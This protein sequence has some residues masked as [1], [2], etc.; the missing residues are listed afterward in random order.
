MEWI[1]VFLLLGAGL[2]AGFVAGLIG[3]GG[4]IIFAPVLFF[5]F[6]AT[7]VGADVIAPLTVGSSLLCTLV[8]AL[9]SAWSQVRRESV[10]FRVA[11][12]VGTSSAAAV[13]LMT[14]FVTTR[15]WYDA[16]VFQVL[17]SLVLLTVVA[18]MVWHRTGEAH[19]NTSGP[20]RAVA[21][22]SS[23]WVLGT[24]GTAAGVVASAV[25]VGGGVV[26]VPAYHN[27]LRLSIHRSVGTSSATIVLISLVGVLSYAVAGGGASVPAT[28]VGFVD[29]GH[30]LLL[31]GPALL[32][33]RWGVGVAHRIDTRALRWS[34]A[35]VA[36][37]VAARLLLDALGACCT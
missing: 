31:A 13:F 7:G 6:D 22:R 21:R 24:T 9:S 3:V 15:P 35:V 11:A 29:A 36:T 33:A 4:G 30:A 25:G 27:V 12:V 10:L 28:A 1:T 20:A 17:F 37:V 2:A 16:A 14:R 23:W 32:S 34:F 26:L 5:Y 18:R 19:G 8:A